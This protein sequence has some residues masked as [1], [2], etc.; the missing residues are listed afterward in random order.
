MSYLQKTKEAGRH[1]F[2]DLARAW[3]HLP[4]PLPDGVA[5]RT[6]GGVTVSLPGAQIEEAF[7]NPALEP[8]VL[9][10]AVRGDKARVWLKD[11]PED[12]SAVVLRVTQDGA[13]RFYQLA[14]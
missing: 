14:L 9:Q 1:V 7:A 10:T 13:E 11:A 5:Q 2:P 4:E 3:A 8:A 6:A 12:G